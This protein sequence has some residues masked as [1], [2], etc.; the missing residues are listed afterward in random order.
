M[1]TLKE[2]SKFYA[3]TA[4]LQQVSLSIERGTCFGLIGPNGAGKSTLMKV[5]VGIIQPDAGSVTLSEKKVQDWKKM[6]GYIPQEVCLEDTITAKQQLEFYGDIHRL[7]KKI[8]DTRM[9]FIL[10][11]VGL[12]DRKHDKINTFSSGMKRRL[13]IACALLHEPQVILMD[14]PTVGIDPQSRQA[15]FDLIQRL[16]DKQCTILYSSHYIEEVEKICDDVAF[17]DDGKII[18]TSRVKQL[19]QQHT[20]P[21]IYVEWTD[22]PPASIL[23]S[24][25]D[26]TPYK[27]GVLMTT[28]QATQIQDLQTILDHTKKA[29]AI[30]DQLTFMQSSLEEIF[31]TYT[32][33]ALRDEGR[34]SN[35]E[36]SLYIRNAEKHSR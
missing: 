32:G 13:H 2:I 20:H 34:K 3:K 12:I 36:S 33:T 25:N 10:G 1:L 21:Q 4:A 26:I 23:H 27:Q 5:I 7:P 35:H 8:R 29:E 24:I 9:D 16:K 31:F 17:I 19:I 18:M 28:S 14:E 22:A 6:I 15:I 30:L 11:E